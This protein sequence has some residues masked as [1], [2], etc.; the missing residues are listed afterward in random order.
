MNHNTDHQMETVSNMLEAV[1]APVACLSPAS[2]LAN[3]P[4]PCSRARD[5]ACTFPVM[6]HQDLTALPTC[7]DSTLFQYMSAVLCA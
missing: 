7:Q 6:Q 1:A 3:A 2:Q 5:A 4:I